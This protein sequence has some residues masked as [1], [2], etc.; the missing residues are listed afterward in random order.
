[1]GADSALGGEGMR[2][3][4]NLHRPWRGENHLVCRKESPPRTCPNAGPGTEG[5]HQRG[6]QRPI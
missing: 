1:M 6:G 2:R 3:F 4:P 5:M